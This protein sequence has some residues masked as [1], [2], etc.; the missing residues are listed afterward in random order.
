MLFLLAGQIC[1]TLSHF[2]L[3]YIVS[4]NS[5]QPWDVL[6][7]I[8]KEGIISPEILDRL[9]VL[10]LKKKPSKFHVFLLPRNSK[11]QSKDAGVP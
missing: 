8:P 11:G 3:D 4:F 9:Y 1:L 7:S 6:L 10:F 5:G 2:G